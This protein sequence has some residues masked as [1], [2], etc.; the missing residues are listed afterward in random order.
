VLFFFHSEMDNRTFKKSALL[1]SIS[2]YEAGGVYFESEMKTNMTLGSHF[3][4][5]FL[6]IAVPYKSVAL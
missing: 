2:I 1:P 6:S 5:L 4:S 3:H